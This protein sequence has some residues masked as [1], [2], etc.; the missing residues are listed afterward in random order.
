MR[1][2]IVQEPRP[3]DGQ[4]TG[5]FLFF[6]GVG[7]N[8]EDLRGIC[9]GIA[10]KHP[11][12][13]VVSVQSPDPSDLGRGWQWFS[14]RGVTAENRPLR[15]AATM[16]RFAQAIATWQR[17]TGLDADRTTLVGFSQGAIMALEATQLPQRVAG[18]VV[19][20]AG[21][22]A[23]TPQRAPQGT[24]IHLLHV[25]EDGVVPAQAS[26]EAHAQLA[27]LHAD[28]SLDL[29]PGLGHGIDARMA[30]RLYERLAP[31]G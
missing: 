23:A 1:D 3:A 29:L 18:R 17:Q 25:Q 14:V 21:R 10:A 6:H 28:V 27:A 26:I 12:A 11:Q 8:A 31:A 7:S 16:P 15:V 4:A 20:M 9:S 19:A 5:L 2:L 30:A 22:F 24:R 13:W